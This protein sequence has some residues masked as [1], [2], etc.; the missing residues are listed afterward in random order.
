LGN[1][2][3]KFKNSSSGFSEEEEKFINSIAEAD[4]ENHNLAFL[5]KKQ[6]ISTI[7]LAK[8]IEESSKLIIESNERLS[9]ST[10]KQ[11]KALN[12]LTLLLVALTIIMLLK[13]FNIF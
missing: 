11:A 10:E 12:W 3:D 4:N 1:I 6:A 13:M 9:K 7:Y 8:Q 2:F 5:N